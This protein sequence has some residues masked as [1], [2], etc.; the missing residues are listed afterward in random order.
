MLLLAAPVPRTLMQAGDVEAALRLKRD[1]LSPFISPIPVPKCSRVPSE[2]EAEWGRVCRAY[3]MLHGQVGK[4]GWQM[5][6]SGLWIDCA[7]RS[8]DTTRGWN[9]PQRW[10][11]TDHTDTPRVLPLIKHMAGWKEGSRWS[12]APPT[13]LLQEKVWTRPPWSPVQEQLGSYGKIIHIHVLTCNQ[14][15]ANLTVGFIWWQQ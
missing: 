5:S 12:Q 6:P 4:S 9:L 15:R 10:P 8:S 14:S 3:M 1:F 11:E 13:P 2:R 7:F